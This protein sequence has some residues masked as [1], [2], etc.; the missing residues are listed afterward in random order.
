MVL[1]DIHC[2]EAE[3]IALASDLSHYRVT[4]PEMIRHTEGSG[5]PALRIPKRDYFRKRGDE[6]E[7]VLQ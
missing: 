7:A 4:A 5:P 3:A 6:P 2:G 1:P